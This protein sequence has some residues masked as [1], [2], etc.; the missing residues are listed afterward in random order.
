MSKYFN[1]LKQLE[2]EKN[3]L[4]TPRTDLPKPPKAPFVSF[5]STDRHI[6]VKKISNDERLHEA[7]Q[8]KVMALLQ[9]NP[10]V[11]RVVYADTDSD[12]LN[13]IL[14]IAVRHV[15]VTEMTIPR[16]KYDSWRLMAVLDEEVH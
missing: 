13:V 12:P 8:E 11:P 14:A 1:R 3:S 2:T 9:E 5:V 10:D 4:Y 15:A 6:N 16:D 7:R